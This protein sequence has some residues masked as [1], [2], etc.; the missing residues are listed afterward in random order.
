MIEPGI[1]DMAPD[2]FL[3]RNPKE[4]HRG[5][6]IGQFLGTLLFCQD[7][8]LHLFKTLRRI[9]RRGPFLIEELQGSLNGYGRCHFPFPVTAQS[10]RQNKAAGP[11]FFK[12]SYTVFVHLSTAGIAIK[13][14]GNHSENPP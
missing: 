8:L 11:V 14:I 1:P 10:I 6:H 3:L 5:L 13:L 12:L 9:C 7:G 2:H 4:N